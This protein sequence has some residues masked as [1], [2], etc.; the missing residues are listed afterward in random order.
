MRTFIHKLKIRKKILKFLVFAGIP[1]TYFSA[2]WLKYVKLSGI[3]KIENKIFMRIGILPVLDH[4]Y[5]PMINPGKYLTKSLR[6]DRTLTGI[7]FNIEEQ[8]QLL[9]K[10]SYNKEL[11]QIPLGNNDSFGYYYN[12]G[13]YES[14]DAEY[15][16][17]IIRH[18]KPGRIIEIG[19]GWSTLI[20]L[21]ALSQNKIEDTNYQCQHICVE[22]YEYQWLENTGVELLRVKAEALEKSF[23]RKLE[24]NDIL[25][26]D[27][28]HIIRPQGDVL[29]EYLEILPV[30]N[31]G[32]LIHVHDIFT[33]KDYPNEWIY[34]H[35]FWNEQYLL[36]AFL[37]FNNQFKIVGALNYLAHHYY[38]ELSSKCP[39]F[40][41][42][43][44]K[45][46]GAFWIMKM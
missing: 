3:G 30:L 41:N 16:Y 7:N 15:F 45:E 6:D 19:S 43:K 17:N 28:S 9:S 26:I 24:A 8:L 32:V 13:N 12:N 4:Y 38:N 21:K 14:G 2:I 27:S 34:N 35:L 46:P 11:V 5:Q 31:S 18:F 25:F 42:Q 10:F 23:F 36:E 29:F 39:V 20:A 33:P 22:P 1:I 40:S 37:M 44:G